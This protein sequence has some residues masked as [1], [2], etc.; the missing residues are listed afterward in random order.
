MPRHAFMQS[1]GAQAIEDRWMGDCLRR[2][3][4]LTRIMSE[5][6]PKYFA[7]RPFD[8]PH[9]TPANGTKGAM[10]G[11]TPMAVRAGWRIDR[12]KKPAQKGSG[13]MPADGCAF[14]H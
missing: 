2:K 3:H 8:K 7:V 9:L 6:Q 11:D 4:P 1:Y 13:M 12:L 14:V 10:A 5:G